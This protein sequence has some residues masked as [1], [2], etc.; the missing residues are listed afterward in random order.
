M[1]K[2][3]SKLTYAAASMF[4]FVSLLLI[5]GVSPASAGPHKTRPHKSAVKK[6][7]AAVKK[8]ENGP[9][10]W[11]G[12][13]EALKKARA[14]NKLVMVDFYTTWCT[15]CKKLDKDTYSDPGVIKAL[16][17]DFIVVK[18]DA[19]SS[20]KVMRNGKSVTP[21]ELAQEYGAIG[22]PAIRFLD[23]DGKQVDR[24]DGY[25][26][27]EDFLKFIGEVKAGKYH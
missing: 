18:I 17:A 1:N 21:A 8:T 3:A 12:Y 10:K 27:P 24:I 25:A 5:T 15:W 7:D 14:E 4:F 2:N 6:K 13:E 11:L 26:P 16:N 23:K 22:Y 20:K 19:E 9:L